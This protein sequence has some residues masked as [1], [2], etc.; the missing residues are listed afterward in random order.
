MSLAGSASAPSFG[1]AHCG[2]AQLGDVRRTRS[3][4]DLANR[5]HRPPQGSLPL[6]FRD[7]NAL[8]RCYDLMNTPSVT[9]AAVLGPHAERTAHLLWEQPGTVLLLPDPTALD[10][11]GHTTRHA[12]LGQIGNGFRR[13]YLGQHRLAVPPGPRGVRGLL[14]QHRPVRAD[15]PADASRA[16]RRDRQDRERLRWRHGVRA[17]AAVVDR[18]RR[19]R[20]RAGRPAGPRVVAVCDRGGATFAFFDLEDARGRGFVVRSNQDRSLQV[21]HAGPA[22]PVPLHGHVRTLPAPA[23]RTLTAHGRDGQPDRP[24]TVA[25]AWAAVR[26]PPPRPKRGPWR[27]QTLTLWAVRVWE[28]GPVP[29]GAE[30]VEWFRLT[31]VAVAGVSDAWERVDWY[32]GRWAVEERHKAPK[33]GGDREAPPFTTPGALPP[34]IALLSVVAVSRRQLRDRGRAATPAARPAAD[35]VPAEEVAVLSGWRYGTRRDLRVGEFD[36]ALA[37]LGGHPNRRHDR[38]AGWL[39]LWRGWQ[40]LPLRVAGARAVACPPAARDPATGPAQRPQRP[41]QEE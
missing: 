18:V 7:P 22:P 15:V 9:H 39:V 40:A 36:Q 16:Q 8:R 11:T 37:R 41:R 26:L 38:P 32:C 25:V 31:N 4:G 3:L 2:Q 14:P 19:P 20:R 28:V 21:G 29:A 35:V 1:E 17:A 13:G 24:V 6:K 10:F 34:M 12:D 27:G 5:R 23:R 30:P 33:T